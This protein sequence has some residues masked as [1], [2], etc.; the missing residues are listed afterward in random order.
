[1]LK[2]R[3]FFSLKNIFAFCLIITPI[4]I[5]WLSFQK[6]A[7]NIPH[8]DDF[9]VRN[10]L[11]QIFQTDSMS[12]KLKILFAQHNEHRIFLTR[13]SAWFIYQL[14]GTLDL[15]LLMVLGI[16]A[17]IGILILFYNLSKKYK[18][19]LIAFTPISFLIFNVG[20]FEN[21]FWGMASIQ[22]FGVIFFAFLTFYFL[23]YSIKKKHNYYLYFALFSCFLGIF[24]SSNGIIIPL[25]GCVIL[26][27][28]KQKKHFL[29]WIGS[30]IL[31][32][33]SFFY[34]FEKNPDKAASLNVSDVNLLVK[35]LFAT[36]GSA[37]DSSF[38]DLN[39]HLDLSM[40][41]G[42]LLI[43]FIV[44]FAYQVIFK[45]YNI[46]QKNNDL[47]LLS[48]L[49]FIGVTC[50]GIVLAR[51]SFGIGILLTSKYKIYSILTLVIFYFVAVNSFS[52]KYRNNFILLSVLVSILFNFYTYIADYQNIRYLNQER[53]CEQFVQQV[54]EKSFPTQGIMAK[55][56]RPHKTFFDNL[57]NDLSRPI[58]TLKINLRIKDKPT[59]YQLYNK[60]TDFSIN[61]TSPEAG[62]YFILKSAKDVYLCPTKISGLGK[63]AYLDRNFLVN[64]ILKVDNFTAEI[65]KF[66][67]NDGKYRIGQ[68]LVQN[69]IK[70]I[71]WTNQ[72]IDIVALKKEK[73]QQNW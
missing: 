55:L 69:G 21:T 17:L 65:D 54:S 46:E 44:L 72:V 57:I 34:G 45:K 14:Q 7:V 62:L 20:L 16:L 12:E 70:T 39:K 61:L 25:I 67:F 37:I 32:L 43:L 63:K 59:N 66:Y 42:L 23:V 71:S 73:T 26:L 64:N 24:T 36:F 8:W 58:D 30:S 31:F 29:I 68:V 4:L 60:Q 48:C 6:Y 19:P 10:S 47:F 22:N 56:Q 51:I 52:I 9:A 15:K 28:Q 2:L 3:L 27:F 35:G 1:M 5:F 53:I 49:M 11:A 41:V 40:A 33:V 38:I 13:I 18:F 50:V